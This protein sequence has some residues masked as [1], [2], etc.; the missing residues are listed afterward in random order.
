M[1]LANCRLCLYHYLDISI[2]YFLRF[3][4]LKE[5]NSIRDFSEQFNNYYESEDVIYCKDPKQQ[6]LYIKH[7]AKLADIFYSDV[8]DRIVFVFWRN[9]KSNEL[10]KKWKLHELV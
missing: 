9:K 10:Y 8:D 1:N 3:Y 4:Y 7:H 6:K 2:A 5:V